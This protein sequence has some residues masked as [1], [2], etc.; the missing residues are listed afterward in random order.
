METKFSFETRSHHP[1]TL[2]ACS[3]ALLSSPTGSTLLPRLGD[4]FHD[5]GF[6]SLQAG[7][8]WVGHPV[9]GEAHSIGRWAGTIHRCHRTWN[10]LWGAVG[11][12]GSREKNPK[13]YMGVVGD[14]G[15]G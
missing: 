11:G 6:V 3:P 12:R 9:R 13:L 1:L 7:R 2:A 8:K 4:I 10:P 15:S 14:K 5:H